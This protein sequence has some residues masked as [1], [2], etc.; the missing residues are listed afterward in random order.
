MYKQMT[1]FDLCP[2]SQPEPDVWAYVLKHGAVICRIM[3]HGIRP[4]GKR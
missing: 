3:R 4:G 1:I 2:A